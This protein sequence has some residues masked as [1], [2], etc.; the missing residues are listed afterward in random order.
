[1]AK[2]TAKRH[3]RMARWRGGQWRHQRRR[4]SGKLTGGGGGEEEKPGVSAMAAWQHLQ[5][6]NM[7]K[8]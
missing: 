1:M 8:A 7:A 4:Q 5:I 6:H 2:T 3:Q